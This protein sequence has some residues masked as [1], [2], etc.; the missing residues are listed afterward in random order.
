MEEGMGKKRVN[1]FIDE[2]QVEGLKALSRATRVKM[3]DYVREGIDLI[4]AKY[5]KELKKARKKGGE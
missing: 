5:Q 4:L 1:F 3:S 2:M